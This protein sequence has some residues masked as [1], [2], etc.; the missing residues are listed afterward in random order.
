MSEPVFSYGSI[1]RS[2]FKNSLIRILFALTVLIEL[3][4]IT[5]LPAYLSTQKAREAKAVAD[6]VSL[7]RK[8]RPTLPNRKLSTK[9]RSPLTPGASSLP[10]RAR[11]RRSPTKPAM[12]PPFPGRHPI[13][14][15]RRPN[16]KP[17]RKRLKPVDQGGRRNP[18]HLQFVHQTPKKAQADMA[19]L[20]AQ[21]AALTNQLMNCHG[22][23]IAQGRC[24]TSWSQVRST[25]RK[26]EQRDASIDQDS[27]PFHRGP[28]ASNPSLPT[29]SSTCATVPASSITSL[30]KFL[31]AP[32]IFASSRPAS[33]P[34]MPKAIMAGAKCNGT[35][36]QALFPPT[37]STMRSNNR[38]PNFTAVATATIGAWT[39][40]FAKPR[41]QEPWRPGI[42][43]AGRITIIKNR[44]FKPKPP[45]NAQRHPARQPMAKR[46]RKPTSRSNPARRQSTD[47]SRA[48]ASATRMVEQGAYRPQK[49]FP[50]G[51][52]YSPSQ[53]SR[54]RS[55]RLR[56]NSRLST[57]MK[58]R[59]LDRQ[60]FGAVQVHRNAWPLVGKIR[61]HHLRAV[62]RQQT[63]GAA[64]ALAR[65][66]YRS[67]PDSPPND[68]AAPPYPCRTTPAFP[69][70][71]L[72]HS[73]PCRTEPTDT[74]CSRRFSFGR[75]KQATWAGP[76]P[77][78]ANRFRSSS[79]VTTGRPCASGFGI[80]PDCHRR[81][82]AAPWRLI[83]ESLEHLIPEIFQPLRNCGRR[84]ARAQESARA[85]RPG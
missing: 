34:T 11:Q 23:D 27:G 16:T 80:E 35:A 67:E 7:R 60:R 8:A 46:T 6:N 58:H 48:S 14:P 43:A 69:R 61:E 76:V 15:T 33:G 45:G 36:P 42:D 57:V 29:A 66:R 65:Q 39:S 1:A 72:P 63:P 64:F 4:D 30:S 85:F 41:S 31:L 49:G 13:T 55:G 20:E 54:T 9:P 84:T 75:M 77:S 44:A 73:R 10:R 28:L 32:A 17:R 25:G 18:E 59:H 38:I 26:R 19:Q 82:R 2:L 40:L 79:Q 83:V 78:G 3:Y 22:I 24:G 12:K 81:L 21:E 74:N 62:R 68:N 52:T 71:A 53:I 51:Q 47:R 70:A 56:I 37:A 50:C 5:A